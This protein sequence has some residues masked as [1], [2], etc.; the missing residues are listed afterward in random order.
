MVVSA[1]VFLGIALAF[2]FTTDGMVQNASGT[3]LYASMVYAAAVF[4]SPRLSPW[5][6]GTIAILFC[7]LV[8][9][10]QLTG[11]P[12][13]LSARSLIARLVLGVAFDPEDMVWYPVGVL[14]LVAAHIVIKRAVAARQRDR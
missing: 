6:A 10:S 12:A 1:A 8:E 3:A 14:P 11:V 2:R 7:W 4:V 13:Y 5:L 9:I